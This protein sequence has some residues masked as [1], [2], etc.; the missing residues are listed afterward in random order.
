MNIKKALASIAITA[1]MLVGGAVASAP[2]QA[3]TVGTLDYGTW[4][5]FAGIEQGIST[6]AHIRVWS[7]NGVENRLHLTER[8]RNAAK[9][10]PPS[11][12]Y[13]LL[14]IRPD[15]S[16]IYL[17]LGECRD[18]RWAAE[19]EWLVYLEEEG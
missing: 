11:H 4:I 10:C 14:L 17:G 12:D 2:A 18:L 6:N 3:D 8:Q 1:G 16:G 19:G 13:S 15:S 9:I 5:R 7:M